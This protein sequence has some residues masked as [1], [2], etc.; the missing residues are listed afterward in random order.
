MPQRFTFIV[1]T[2]VGIR[3]E[4]TAVIRRVRASTC[5]VLTTIVA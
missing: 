3:A 1:I 4:R 2:D 5:F